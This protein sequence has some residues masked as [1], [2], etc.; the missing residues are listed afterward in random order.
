MGR[1]LTR[2]DGEGGI[3]RYGAGFNTYPYW[4][5]NA[6]GS[7][8]D[9]LVDPTRPTLQTDAVRTALSFLQDATAV[10]RYAARGANIPSFAGERYS[11]YMHAAPS[12]TPYL[13]NANVNWQW[14]Y[15]AN[16][17][18]EWGGS[19]A[20]TVG[21]SL[22]SQ[23]ANP[24]AAWKWMQFLATEAAPD[25]IR[26]TGRLVAWGPV[27]RDY[28]EHFDRP[29][30]WEHVWVELISRTDSFNRAIAAPTVFSTWNSYLGPVLDGTMPPEVAAEEAQRHLTAVLEANRLVP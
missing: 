30:D 25:H 26:I 2:L 8:F 5:H 23:S 15:A 17:K 12:N 20:L 1:K 9:R 19:E 16:P 3:A 14:S 6:G 22:S 21:V 4:I 29:T 18:L 7:M 11:I 13:Q 10:S 24:E 28:L 27:G